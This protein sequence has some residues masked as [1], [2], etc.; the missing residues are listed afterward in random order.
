MDYLKRI[1]R[2]KL[3]NSVSKNYK[4]VIGITVIFIL[5]TVLF[6]GCI[7]Q[8]ASSQT[9]VVSDITMST[10]VDSNNRPINPTTVFA[11]NAPG[12]YCSFLLSG[13]PVNAK[14]E[15]KWIY[16]G[17]DPET[18]NITGNNYVLDTQ[19]ALIQKEGRGYTY[20]M[21]TQPGMPDYKFPKGEY[22]VVISVDG[23]EKGNTIFT[24][25]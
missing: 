23:L 19:T 22:Q 7:K 15:A 25:Q 13:F 12:F 5:A 21:Y 8:A 20:T 9:G 14:L 3:M 18:E 2:R 24:V 16:V 10:G 17:G 4:S 1:L 6:T 11:T